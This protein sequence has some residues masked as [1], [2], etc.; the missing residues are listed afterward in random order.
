M[1]KHRSHLRD[2]MVSQEKLAPGAMVC[3]GTWRLRTSQGWALGNV[4]EGCAPARTHVAMVMTPG[5][6]IRKFVGVIWE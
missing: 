4:T 6:R 5:Q 1:K 2:H 3:P